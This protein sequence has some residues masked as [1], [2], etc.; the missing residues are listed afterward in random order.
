MPR[1]F[2][3][4]SRTDCLLAIAAAVV[5]LTASRVPY[6]WWRSRSVTWFHP[7]GLLLALT[8]VA[9]IL[10]Y[11]G[12]VMGINVWLMKG[13]F[14]AIPRDIDESAMVDGA[15]HWQ[16]FRHLILPLVRPILAV[17][18]ILTFIGNFSDFVLARVMLQSTEEFTLMVGMYLFVS[19]QFSKNWGV[20]A[21]G[22]LIGGI[23]IVLFYLALQDQIV[24]GLTQGSVKG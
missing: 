14:D 15:S 10:V 4:R 23:P 13:F 7:A 12:G 16:T 22:G 6:R 8:V 24:G 9:L 18:G 3:R 21:A 1:L 20:F 2:P 5:M 19:D 11:L 17:V